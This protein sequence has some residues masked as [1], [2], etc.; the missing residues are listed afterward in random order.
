LAP[1]LSAYIL[2]AEHRYFGESLPFG[3][4]SF[5][6]GNLNYCTTEQ[7][8]GDYV[9]FLI[10]YKTEV[11]NCYDC[12]VIA[13][14]GSY[15]GMLTAW[16]RMKFPN[17]IDGGIAASAP[18]RMF[19]WVTDTELSYEILS[20]DFGNST[21]PGCASVSKEGFSRLYNY[22][23]I[24]GNQYEVTSIFPLNFI[25]L[26]IKPSTCAHPSRTMKK[27]LMLLAGSQ[28][29]ISQLGSSIIHTRWTT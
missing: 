19:D 7:A 29:H 28:V 26:L 16:M 5:N 25:R 8:M 15:G 18:I 11:L 14:G 6:E 21:T 9:D 27:L 1:Q 17:I 13:F 3:N 22:S 24:N 12:P 20:W 23:Q 10:Y 4:D 2:F